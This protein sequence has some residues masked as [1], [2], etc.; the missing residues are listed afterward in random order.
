[1]KLLLVEDDRD[2]IIMLKNWLNAHGYEIYCAS[3]CEKA[4]ALWLEQHPDLVII[5]DDLSQQNLLSWC[6][7]MR[8][9]YDTLV[10][11][12]SSTRTVENELRWLEWG[13]DNYLLKP[14]FP[15]QLLARI[16][17]LCRRRQ[18]TTESRSSGVIAVGEIKVDTHRHLVTIANK[19]IRL[20]ALENDLLHFLLINRGQ[21]C[22]LEQIISR[23]WPSDETPDRQLVRAHIYHLRK[24]IEADPAHPRYIVTI[25]GLGYSFHCETKKE[26]AS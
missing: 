4:S 9:T 18:Y 23:V 20:T 1:M 24:K 22:S 25:P 16:R 14:F 5:D 15:R 11:V 7:K 26:A 13:A 19:T 12:M 10:F 6:C 17:S 8:K 2:M 21:I 3:T